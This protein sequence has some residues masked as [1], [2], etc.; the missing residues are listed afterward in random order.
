MRGCPF[1]GFLSDPA[2]GDIYDSKYP[3]P[4]CGKT[5]LLRKGLT[6]SLN[7]LGELQQAEK[8]ATLAQLGGL[9]GAFLYTQYKLSASRKSSAADLKQTSYLIPALGLP[10]MVK[11]VTKEEWP[12]LSTV[13]TLAVGG[14][15]VRNTLKTQD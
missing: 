1:C 9:A 7:G 2:T 8:W 5:A 10:S 6:R 13:Y 4:K 11:L 15:L 14:L 3:C 12:V